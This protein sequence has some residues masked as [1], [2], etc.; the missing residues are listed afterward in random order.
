MC[1][2]K[3]IY[4]FDPPL[5]LYLGSEGTCFYLKLMM[6]STSS[7]L[8]RKLKPLERIYRIWYVNFSLRLWRFWLQCDKVYSLEKNYVTPNVQLCVELNAHGL[9]SSNIVL[10]TLNMPHQ[11]NTSQM[12]SQSCESFFRSTRSVSSS[13]S[14]QTNFTFFEFE[15][16]RSKKVDVSKK[17]TAQGVVDGIKYPRNRQPFQTEN[18]Q[19]DEDNANATVPI[20]EL[21]SLE[22]I[23]IEIMRAERDSEYDLGLLG[24][25][26]IVAF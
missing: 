20:E 13:G 14:S 21:A 3:L 24:K 17:I 26:E 16:D 11:F 5:Q 12:G 8:D 15:V 4:I 19:N 25:T 9:V 7:Y 18:K 10:K 22:E 23:E 6:Y 1:K 2:S